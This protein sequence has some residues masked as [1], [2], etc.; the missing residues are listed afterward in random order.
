MHR[1]GWNFHNDI[2]IDLEGKARRFLKYADQPVNT[3]FHA[4]AIE[5]DGRFAEVMIILMREKSHM[6]R[7]SDEINDFVSTC[8]PYIGLSGVEIGDEKANEL[9]ESFKNLWNNLSD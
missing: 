7:D 2:A 8:A 5:S 3:I 6:Q 4:G 1:E 9:Y